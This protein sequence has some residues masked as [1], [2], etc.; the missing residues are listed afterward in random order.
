MGM[1]VDGT[2]VILS[3]EGGPDGHPLQGQFLH[4]GEGSGGKRLRECDEGVQIIHVEGGLGIEVI[5]SLDVDGA[6]SP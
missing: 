4:H 2:L 1:C 6:A 3:G 5:D